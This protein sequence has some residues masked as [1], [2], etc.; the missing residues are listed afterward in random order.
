[1]THST[2]SARD[3]AMVTGLFMDPQGAERAYEA[4]LKRGYEIGEVN[5]LMSDSTRQ[6]LLSDPSQAS[7]ELAHHK[8][9]GGELGG[10]AGGR[11]SILISIVA[12]VGA[13]VALPALGLVAAGPVAAALTAAGAAGLAAGVLGAVA[14]WGLPEERVREYEAGIRD[15]GILMGVTARSQEDARQIEEEW[16]ALGGRHVYA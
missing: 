13:A 12:A 16:K 7:E 3:P 10:P 15:G 2:P 8:A 1:M 9:E 14:R 5:A 4:C 11:L 6:R